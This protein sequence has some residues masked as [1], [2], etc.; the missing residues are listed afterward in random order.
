MKAKN[1]KEWRQ[2]V[3]ERD[4]YNCQICGNYG[5]VADHIEPCRNFPKLVLE[6]NNGRTLCIPCHGRVGARV[7]THEPVTG[8]KFFIDSIT[9]NPRF[10]WPKELR[11]Q[12]YVGTLNAIPNACIVVIP[13]PKAK[14]KDIAKSLLILA[15]DFKHR[16]EIEEEK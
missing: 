13:K 3:L 5:N 10:Y 2:K 8:N 6:V 4:N 16:A 11:E 9:E 14:N 15:E 7:R 1:L 12:G